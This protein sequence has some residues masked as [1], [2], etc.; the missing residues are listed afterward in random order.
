MTLEE[1]R[2]IISDA[3]KSEEAAYGFY[4][5]VARKAS[6]KSISAIFGNFAA[7]E[8]AHKV[9]LEGYLSRG[10]SA[11]KFDTVSDYKVSETVDKPVL[12]VDM[13]PAEAIALAMKNEEEAMNMYTE[14]ANLSTDSEQKEAFLGLARMEQGHKAKLEDLYVG[15]AYTEVW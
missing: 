11:L 5:D 4:S 1:F 15:I 12:S 14:F 9:L 6:D 10:T 3:V 13:R 7:E 2:R 8:L